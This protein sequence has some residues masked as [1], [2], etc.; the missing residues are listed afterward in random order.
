MGEGEDEREW[1]K[2]GRRREDDGKEEEG[3]ETRDKQ[4][5]T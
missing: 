3:R 1:R 2:N 5:H 4:T